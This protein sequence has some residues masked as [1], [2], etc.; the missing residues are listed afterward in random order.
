MEIPR[1]AVMVVE[2][3]KQIMHAMEVALRKSGVRRL[4]HAD[5]SIYLALSE[6]LSEHGVSSQA[7]NRNCVLSLGDAGFSMSSP[8]LVPALLLEGEP[9]GLRGSSGWEAILKE[10]LSHKSRAKFYGSRKWNVQWK[11]DLH[12]ITPGVMYSSIR[13]RLTPLLHRELV[14]LHANDLDAAVAPA[15]GHGRRPRF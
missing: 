2:R 8:E 13:E 3:K 7:V 11:D 14:N 4:S 15:T 10:C 1:W 5:P 9:V 6:A 12:P